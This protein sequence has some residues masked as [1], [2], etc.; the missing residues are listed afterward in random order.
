MQKRFD[1]DKVYKTMELV[2]AAGINVI[3]NYLFGLPEDDLESMQ[4]TLDLALE[5]NCEFA[6][7]YCAMAFPGSQLYNV[8]V[9]EGWPRDRTAHPGNG[10]LQARKEVRP[11]RIIEPQGLCIFQ[12]KI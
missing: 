3:A 9:K 10:L 1:Q 5:L 7:F 4:A 2:R 6:N 12:R 8:A 11:L